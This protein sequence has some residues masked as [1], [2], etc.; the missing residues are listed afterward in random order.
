MNTIDR[1]GLLTQGIEV[2]SN[3]IP[4]FKARQLAELETKEG[5]NP[6][7]KTKPIKGILNAGVLTES[8]P[9]VT[10]WVWC[11]ALS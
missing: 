4:A 6:A 2:V 10:V 9:E 8:F 5:Y 1:V 11:R 3:N 7:R